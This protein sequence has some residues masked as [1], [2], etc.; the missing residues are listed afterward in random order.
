M[1]CDQVVAR[2]FLARNGDGLWCMSD[3]E[4]AGGTMEKIAAAAR[5]LKEFVGGETIYCDIRP[6]HPR[7]EAL[8]RLYESLGMVE[9]V[10]V[11]RWN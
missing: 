11:M 9:D 2:V 1:D 8:M 3:L 6:D 7:R 4:S 5:A 10:T